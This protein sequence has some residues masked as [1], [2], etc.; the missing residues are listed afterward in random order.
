MKTM[1]VEKFQRE[2]ARRRGARRRGAPR[3]P[4]HL[5]AFAVE[6]VRAAQA[7]GRSVHAAAAEIGLNSVTMGAWLK[8]ASERASSRL[9]EV[10]VSDDAADLVSSTRLVITAPSGHI[11]SGLSVAD[12]AVLLRALR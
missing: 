8:R 9:R 2:V 3:Y 10:V 6:H 7:M 11:V 4:D 5:V 1:T 12:A